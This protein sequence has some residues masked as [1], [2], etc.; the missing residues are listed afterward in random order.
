MRQ[1]RPCLRFGSFALLALCL[2]AAAGSPASGQQASSQYRS[3]TDVRPRIPD[4]HDRPYF[5]ETQS[6]RGFEIREPQFTVIA[7]TSAADARW[8]AA[9]V[10]SGWQNAGELA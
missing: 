7:D 8:A 3:V 5:R 1:I 4:E 9:H 2:L 6:H 10:A